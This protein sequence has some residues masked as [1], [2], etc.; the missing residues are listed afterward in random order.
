[1]TPEIEQY[2]LNHFDNFKKANKNILY[3]LRVTQNNKEKNVQQLRKA[4]MKFMNDEELWIAEV[5][6]ENYGLAIKC[7]KLEKLYQL[8]L[9][10]LKRNLI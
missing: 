1:M 2:Y 3:L 9:A 5:E 6:L 7:D 8:H 4:V 10:N